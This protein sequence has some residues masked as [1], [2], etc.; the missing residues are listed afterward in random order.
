MAMFCYHINES[1]EMTDEIDEERESD[2]PRSR[3]FGTNRPGPAL[4]IGQPIRPPGQEP[5]SRL[6]R[7]LSTPPQSNFVYNTQ[8]SWYNDPRSKPCHLTQSNRSFS[9]CPTNEYV[10]RN[11]ERVFSLRNGRES[12]EALAVPDA[13]YYRIKRREMHT[14]MHPKKK[15]KR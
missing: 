12:R 13:Q 14:R 5:Q 3:V 11:V 15:R 6:D 8:F 4:P 7:Y 9:S 1:A 10:A 2:G